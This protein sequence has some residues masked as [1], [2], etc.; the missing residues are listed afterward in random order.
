M[1]RICVL[2]WKQRPWR[3]PLFL[4]SC[5]CRKAIGDPSQ[6]GR[7]SRVSRDCASL[8]GRTAGEVYSDM[9]WDGSL[10]NS[11][12][13]S[14]RCYSR[15]PIRILPMTRNKSSGVPHN[16]VGVGNGP[17]HQRSSRGKPD[18]SCRRASAIPS[19]NGPLPS[20]E[21]ASQRDFLPGG[22][23]SDSSLSMSGACRSMN[24]TLS[25]LFSLL[26][27]SRTSSRVTL[28]LMASPVFETNSRLR[29]HIAI[30]SR[31]VHRDLCGEAVGRRG[32][33]GW[34]LGSAS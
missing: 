2:F 21:H 8:A 26:A 32:R 16:R 28:T 15:G 13:V 19:S 18:H 1:R 4:E 33:G 3:Q 24:L 27:R 31:P 17:Q 7:Q 5:F 22:L 10:G 34:F 6:A 9:R 30:H 12:W 11:T 23:V 29:K 20:S 14:F 25:T